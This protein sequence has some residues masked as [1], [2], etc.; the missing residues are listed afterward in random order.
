M[1]VSHSPLSG[2]LDVLDL[3][4]APF[5]A[6]L[7][8][9][10]TRDGVQTPKVSK[11][12]NTGGGDDD[13]V[14]GHGAA[15]D[16]DRIEWVYL[17]G[18]EAYGFTHDHNGPYWLAEWWAQVP[19]SKRGTQLRDTRDG[20]RRDDFHSADKGGPGAPC[21]SQGRPSQTH[22]GTQ[23]RGGGPVERDNH[24]NPG[25]TIAQFRANLARI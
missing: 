9:W 24:G 22:W 1:C 7:R 15:G 2:K 19:I 16:T 10:P 21:R 18:D 23:G 12:A 20:E 6:S 11:P 14:G 5:R 4:R 3:G 8:G 25:N 17:D 13:G